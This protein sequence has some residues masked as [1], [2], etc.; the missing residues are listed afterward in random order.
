VLGPEYWTALNHTAYFGVRG[1]TA[2]EAFMALI[3]ALGE[4]YWYAPGEGGNLVVPDPEVI[5]RDHT[6]GR[7]FVVIEDSPETIAQRLDEA[8]RID[9]ERP[10]LSQWAR[11]V[12]ENPDDFEM[13]ARALVNLPDPRILDPDGPF[14]CI[15]CAADEWLFFGFTPIEE[16]EPDEDDAD[17]DAE[18]WDVDNE[19]DD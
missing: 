17:F 3:E 7:G 14:G 18:E 9:E 15:R 4:G 2:E 16:D 19:I 1:A 5:P 11:G 10:W 13:R 8:A 12:R 6:A